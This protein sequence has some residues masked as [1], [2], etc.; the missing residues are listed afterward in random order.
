MWTFKYG[1]HSKTENCK[2]RFGNS[3]KNPVCPEGRWIARQGRFL[4][5]SRMFYFGRNPRRQRHC[6]KDGANRRSSFRLL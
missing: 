5:R 1:D 3:G 2:E 6:K 4:D